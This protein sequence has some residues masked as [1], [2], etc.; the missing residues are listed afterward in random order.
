MDSLVELIKGWKPE[1]Q[2]DLLQGLIVA[3]SVVTV[4]LAILGLLAWGFY[5]EYKAKKDALDQQ[6]DHN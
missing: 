1:A 5:L 3:P 4:I 6:R 2:K